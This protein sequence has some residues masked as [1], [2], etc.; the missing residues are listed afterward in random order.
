MQRNGLHHSKADCSQKSCSKELHVSIDHVSS[1]FLAVIERPSTEMPLGDPFICCLFESA[2][3]FLLSQTL[4]TFI[5]YLCSL[6]DIVLASNNCVAA[7]KEFE[8]VNL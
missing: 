8:S 5:F 2:E 1:L 4:L 3:S 6:L 7:R